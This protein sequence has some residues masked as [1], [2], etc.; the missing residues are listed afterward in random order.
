LV[1]YHFV[2]HLTAPFDLLKAE[3]PKKFN[4]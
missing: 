4:I 2:R 3:V 1:Y